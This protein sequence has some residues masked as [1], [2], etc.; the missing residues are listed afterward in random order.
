MFH[1]KTTRRLT[2]AVFGLIL[3]LCQTLALA[4]TCVEAPDSAP[5]ATEDT[6]HNENRKGTA[7]SGSHSDC[8]SQA[9]SVG[10]TN[11]VFPVI[12]PLATFKIRFD[13]SIVSGSR[14]PL[15]SGAAAQPP[16]IPLILVH[17]RLLN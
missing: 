4:R 2:A 10:Q 5:S 13:Q 16:P 12:A 6:C 11:L 17:C 9:F 7:R 3:M 1:T 14:T 15:A 8:A